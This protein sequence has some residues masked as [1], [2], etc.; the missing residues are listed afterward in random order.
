MKDQITFVGEVDQSADWLEGRCFHCTVNHQMALAIVSYAIAVWK[1]EFIEVIVRSHF[2]VFN[3]FRVPVNA[4]FELGEEDSDNDWQM[5]MMDV[6]EE[7]RVKLR[8]YRFL[9]SEVDYRTDAE[10]VK[11]QKERDKLEEDE[12]VQHFDSKFNIYDNGDEEAWKSDT[13]ATISTS[14][15][16]LHVDDQGFWW[17][18]Y[19]KHSDETYTS[20]QFPFEALNDV[21]EPHEY[22]KPK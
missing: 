17:T 12:D 10:K 8:R 5:S 4:V 1:Y 3:G 11:L 16:R 18:C 9:T 15:H 14:L 22:W 6:P 7:I 20:P 13:P 19:D 21:L 2:E